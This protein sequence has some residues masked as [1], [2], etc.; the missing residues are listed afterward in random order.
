MKLTAD[1]FERIKRGIKTMEVRLF[2]EKRKTMKV[3]DSITFFKLPNLEEST[4]TEIT[5]LSKFNSF[6]ELFSF[7]KTKPFGH[8]EDMTTEEQVLGMRDAYS[9][10]NEKKLGVL[11]IHIK[12]IS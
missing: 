9:E 3:G 4:K 2:D 12:L 10:E 7:F 11:G 6:K 8:P 5:K 1:P